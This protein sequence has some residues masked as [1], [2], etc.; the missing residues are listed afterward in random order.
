MKSPGSDHFLLWAK[1]N[2]AN[3]VSYNNPQQLFRTVVALWNEL[4]GTRNT[5]FVSHVIV[6]PCVSE[7]KEQKYIFEMSRNPIRK[8]IARISLRKYEKTNY[9]V[10]FMTY[11]ILHS[12]SQKNSVAN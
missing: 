10:I 11:R 12:I 4:I 6:R 7:I 9:D 3:T 1:C 5:L 2:G 8:L